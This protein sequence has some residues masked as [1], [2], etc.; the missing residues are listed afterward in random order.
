V[1]QRHGLDH[2][3]DAETATGELVVDEV[4]RSARIDLGLK[5][6]S[7]FGSNGFAPGQHRPIRPS[8]DNWGRFQAVL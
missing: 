8:R 7:M 4:E 6:G 3:E 2:V 5:L 1:A